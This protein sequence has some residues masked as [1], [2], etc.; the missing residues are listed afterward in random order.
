VGL[1]VRQRR[2]GFQNAAGVDARNR[3]GHVDH[4]RDAAGG[5]RQRQGAEVF[6]LRKPR[7]ATV[8]VHV[9][10]AWEHVHPDR[11]HD[12]RA[13]RVPGVVLL[14]RSDDAVGD[15]NID[16][17]RTLGSA[18]GPP[19]DDELSQRMEAPPNALIKL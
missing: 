13:G 18:G 2:L 19:G 15:M 14:E 17:P 9:D 16:L 5:G 8:N 12:A 10:G 3:V 1:A 11:I 7:V 6:L 4:R